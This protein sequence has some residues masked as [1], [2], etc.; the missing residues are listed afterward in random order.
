MGF[1]EGGSHKGGWR[2]V[3]EQ[4]P[5]LEYTGASRIFSNKDSK[6]LIDNT[7]LVNEI[8]QM[9][10]ELF[11]ATYQIAKNTAKSSKITDRWDIDGLPSER[12]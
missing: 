12:T 5:E 6:S 3:G 7:E 2:M 10:Q 8:K 9:R 1:A 4:G 11:A